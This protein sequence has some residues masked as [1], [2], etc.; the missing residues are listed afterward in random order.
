MN[1]TSFKI[2]MAG[3]IY[4]DSNMLVKGIYATEKPHLFSKDETLESLA[5]KGRQVKDMMGTQMFSE[6]YF[7]NLRQCQLVE[8]SLVIDNPVINNT[9]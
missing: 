9:L 1:E 4:V 3:S 2:L 6:S 5:E 8:V 7:E